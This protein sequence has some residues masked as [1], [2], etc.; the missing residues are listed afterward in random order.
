MD[1]RVVLHPR[2][3]VQSPQSLSPS[4]SQR[5]GIHR[6]FGHR[7]SQRV[8]VGGGPVTFVKGALVMM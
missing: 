6:P 5:R 4:H 8:G 1:L 7:Y 2:S 3:S